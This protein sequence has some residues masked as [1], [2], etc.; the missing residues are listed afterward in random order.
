MKFP[1]GEYLYCEL[2]DGTIGAFPSWMADVTRSADV[3]LGPPLASAAALADLRVLLDRL[4][5]GAKHD[6]ASGN[7]VLQEGTHG[8]QGN[9]HDETDE[10]VAGKQRTDKLA[11]RQ[12]TGTGPG[13]RRSAV[14]RSRRRVL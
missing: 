1:R 3:A 8:S 4:P 14:E 10:A 2:P 7:Q 13:T 6:K 11:T 12:A 5:S 9:P